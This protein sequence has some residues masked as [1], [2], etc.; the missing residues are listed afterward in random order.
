MRDLQYHIFLAGSILPPL[1]ANL[2]PMKKYREY[3]NISF[4]T[5]E[6]EVLAYWKKEQVFA[7]SVTNREGKTPFVFYEGPPSA[8]GKPGLH[9]V[10]SRTIKDLFCRYR[11]QKGNYV[12]R[13]AGWDTHGLPVELGVEKALG[14]TKEDIGEKISVADYNKACKE[15]VL[16]FTDIW[17]DLT[18]KMGYWVDLSNPYITYENTYIETC[19]YLLNELFKKDMLYK[20]YSIQPYSPAAGTGLSTHELNQPGCYKNVKDT[21]VVAQFKIL[22]G[23]YQGQGENEFFLAWTTTPW[24][25]PSNTALALGKNIT[26]VKIETFNQYT[27]APITVI[28]AKE[29]A[30][31]YFPAENESADLATY[32]A[33]DKKIPFKILAEYKGELFN[34]V[35]YEQLLPYTTP[36]DGDAF[37]VVLGDFVST[38]DGT[39]IVH[40]APSFGSDDFRVAKQN[41]VGSLTLVDK[42]GKFTAEV[43]D[44]A[45]EYVKE[46]Y[47][48]ADEKPKDYKSVD[49]RIS[50]RLKEENKAFKVEKYEHSYPHCWRTDKPVLYYPLD[51][52]FIKTTAVKDRMIALN[53]TILWKPES[54]GTGRFGN[55]L[56]NLVDW[57]LS[58][59]RYWGIPIPIWTS[60]DKSEQLCIGSFEQLQTE[61]ERSIAAGVMKENPLAQFKV[62]D[63]SKAN[64]TTFDVHRPYV[65]EIILVS[66]TGKKLTRE[67]DLIDVWF[68][69]GAMP[70][71]QLHYPFENKELIDENK[72]FPA[73][74]IAEGVDQTRGWFFTLHAIASMVFDSVAFKAV[75]SNGHVLDKNGNKMSKRLGNVVDPF[76]TIAKYGADATRWYLITNAQPWDS[77][78]FDINGIAEVQRGFF[79]TLYNTYAFFALY[80][81]IDGFTYSEAEVPIERRTELDR[82][83]LSEL[84]SLIK[85]VDAQYA[86]Y[87]PTKAGRAI[88]RFVDD[89]LS[90]WYVRSSRRRFWKGEYSEDKIAAFQTLARCLE[91]VTQLMAPIAP[92]FADRIFSDLNAVTNRFPGVDSVHLADFPVFEEARI[93]AELQ[94]RMQYALNITSMVLSLR[95]KQS[96]K[97]R[98]P[99][100]KIMIPVLDAQM[101]ARIELVKD[102]ILAEVNVKE[103]EYVTDDD[104]GMLVKK[105]K[106]NFKALGPKVGKHM[107][108]VAAQLTAL[109]QEAIARFEKEGKT[110]LSIDGQELSIDVQDVEISSQ[111]IPGWLVSNLDGM[112]VAL[113]IRVS[114]ELKDEGLARELVNRIQNIRKDKGFSVTDKIKVLVANNE[115][116]GGAIKNNKDY[117]CTEVLAQDLVFQDSLA[118]ATEF[119]LDAGVMVG[120]VV[121]R[122]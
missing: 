80:A 86:A 79:G 51:A 87:E 116:L 13:K 17:N 11:T 10:I 32:K 23:Q 81:N 99:L 31:R 100:Q 63:F 92:F 108:T 50:I 43:T 83:I 122:V 9:H 41:G 22:P 101:R 26:Y 73:D 93:D 104:A 85:E 67:T 120:V 65:D 82:W 98:Q 119:E 27:H 66:K 70:Y 97:V 91:V 52:W 94:T 36:K 24:T 53:K 48:A 45:G 54:T 57:N 62:G 39:G 5:I 69:S 6:S 30:A 59:S 61:I 102:L 4:P 3:K 75:V 72:Y 64:Y 90:N 8:N 21:T 106:P 115:A 68:D 40:I 47:L 110:S 96:L 56:E 12:A 58:R 49:V 16:K 121:E 19:W 118:A 42:Q 7:R 14:I 105:I 84:H 60:E 95:T 25:L 78:R 103:I 2:E 20:G 77:L 114:Q 44:Y 111:D 18:E 71:A 76:E 117:I 89:Y 15:D 113:D 1:Y 109:P 107:Q 112:T 28:L 34:G 74:Y 35:R 33:G 88:E 37:R 55:W 38:E 29:C 46:E